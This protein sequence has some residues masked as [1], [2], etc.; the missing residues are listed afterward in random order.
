MVIGVLLVSIWVVGRLTGALQFYRIPTP[1]NEPTIKEGSQFFASSLVKPSRFDFICFKKTSVYTGKMETIV[2]RIC[3]IGGDTV[4]IKNGDLYVNTVYADS[5]F[6]VQHYYRLA[7]VD[8]NKLPADKI[9][10]TELLMPVSSDSV[11]IPLENKWAADNGFKEARHIMFDSSVEMTAAFSQPW[12]VDNFGPVKVPANQFFVLG[13][14]R[15]NAYD[16]RF[17]G[18]VS[19]DSIIA[20]VLW[21]H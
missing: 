7:R 1:A 8:L 4:E 16:S 10:L 19:R 21:K 15:H 13:D 6:R 3:G 20:A 9:P 18:F 12:T 17:W 2:F 5:N 14:N 11:L